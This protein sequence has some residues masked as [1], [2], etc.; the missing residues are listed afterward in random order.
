MTAAPRRVSSSTRQAGTPAAADRA[1]WPRPG[2][3]SAR[4][5]RRS[6]PAA[7]ARRQDRSAAPAAGP[8]ASRSKRTTTA[9]GG[10]GRAPAQLEQPLEAGILLEAEPESAVSDAATPSAATSPASGQDAQATA[11]RHAPTRLWRSSAE[12][13]AQISVCIACDIVATNRLQIGAARSAV[14]RDRRGRR[15]RAAR[16]AA[17]PSPAATR[18]SGRARRSR[19]HGAGGGTGAWHRGSPPPSTCGSVGRELA[20]CHPVGDDTGNLRLRAWPRARRPRRGPARP[21]RGS[22]R[23]APGSSWTLRR[24]ASASA[25]SHAAAA[26]RPAAPRRDG[27]E[28]HRHRVQPALGHHVAQLGLAG[29]VAVDVGVA[30]AERARDVGYRGLGR[31]V[32]AQQLLG[33]GQDALAGRARRDPCPSHAPGRL[34]LSSIR[35]PCAS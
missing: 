25:A 13:L 6:R 8:G 14:A 15:R 30:H 18:P 11:K 24:L 21:A 17:A 33:G 10:A 19:A 5:A 7:A 27:V 3:A 12:T 32:A 29:E 34:S 22:W 9:S 23:T 35:M 4:C 16:P 20:G 2:R 31:A 28:R 1:A 26:R